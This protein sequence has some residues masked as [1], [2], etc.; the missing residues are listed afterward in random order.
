MIQPDCLGHCYYY[1]VIV[2][3]RQVSLI[4]QA[5][6]RL[7]NLLLQPPKCKDYKISPWIQ[8]TQRPW[9]QSFW[10]TLQPEIRIVIIG[11]IRKASNVEDRK[12]GQQKQMREN[13]DHE[14]N[15]IKQQKNQP[16]TNTLRILFYQLVIG[17]YWKKG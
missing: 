9:S 15:R 12:Q 4:P 6:L 16:V 17:C 14:E 8:S 2:I 7:T 10:T 13:R 11:Q 1:F 5:G 3:W